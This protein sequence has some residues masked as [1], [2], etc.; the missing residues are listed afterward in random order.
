MWMLKNSKELL[1]HLQSPKH[2]LRKGGGLAKQEPKFRRSKLEKK[3]FIFLIVR[4][5]GI[6]IW[7]NNFCIL[8]NFGDFGAKTSFFRY[9]IKQNRK[10]L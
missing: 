5:N 10:I 3:L 9:L 7:Q 1:E 4:F 8:S 2:L 6:G